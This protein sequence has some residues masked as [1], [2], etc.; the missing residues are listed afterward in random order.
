M[1]SGAVLIVR[2][3]A[4]Q[5]RNLRLDAARNPRAVRNLHQDANNE[6]LKIT[7]LKTEAW[8]LGTDQLDFDKSAPDLE[9]DDPLTTPKKYE[10]F[11]LDPEMTL[12][13]LWD[14][15]CML[16]LIYCSFSVPYSIAF[17]ESD[18]SGALTSMDYAD[19]AIDIIFMIDIALTF[20]TQFENQGIMEKDFGIIARHY[21]T[22]WF[23]PD[24]AGSFPFD[25]VIASSMGSDGDLGAMKL[26]RMV[27][28]VRAIKF[29]NKLNKLRKKEGMEAFGPAIGICSAMFILL[30]CAHFLGCFF[31]LLAS[32]EHGLTW[33]TR[34][35]ADIYTRDNFTRYVVA[36]YWAVISL[37]TMGYGD[38]VPVTHPERIFAVAVALAGAIVFAHCMGT[39]SSLITQARRKRR[40]REGGGE[41]ERETEGALSPRE[42]AI[43]LVYK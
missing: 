30:F 43:S 9:D 38:L 22:T 42:G 28:L 19:I 1:A 40:K 27:R 18:S 41:G 36:L 11:P 20:V 10:I 31:T 25:M 4:Q 37:T 14:L 16:L 29:L 6:A 33:L 24:L 26:I 12:K 13:Q 3:Q 34:Y 5:G 17:I 23:A 35:D 7:S 15:F 2:N 32:T 8:D 21:I 39:I